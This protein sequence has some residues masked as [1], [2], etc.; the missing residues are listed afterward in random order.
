VIPECG[1][2]AHLAPCRH[3]INFDPPD[4]AAFGAFYARHVEALAGS[5]ND[6]ADPDKV[7]RA[8]YGAAVLY[9]IFVGFCGLQVSRA[10]GQASFTRIAA[11]TA[12]PFSGLAAGE[13]LAY[14][15]MVV[16]QRFPRGVQLS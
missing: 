3:T 14:M 2:D 12:L 13:D 1:P 5:I 6:A 9:A 4:T 8:C 15:Q 7:A 11:R 16:H 10:E